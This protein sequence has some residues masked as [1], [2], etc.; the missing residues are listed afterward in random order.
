[1]AE[2]LIEE[3]IGEHRAALVDGGEIVAAQLRWPGALVAGQVEEAVLTSRNA[4]SARGIARFAGGAEVDVDRLPRDA[5]E[6]AALRLEVVRGATSERGRFKNAQARPTG[7]APRAA[8]RLVETLGGRVVR[9][10]EGWEELW[11]EAL[12]GEVEFPGGRLTI[13]LTAG[14]TVIDIDGSGP[15]PALAREAVPAVAGAIRRLDLSGSI[16][17]DFPTLAAKPDRQAIDAAL[18]QAL[19]GWPHERT[20][21]NGFGLIQIVARRDRPSLLELLARR[22]DAAARML[23]RRAERVREPGTLEL[24]ANPRVRA[25]VRDGWEAELARRTGRAIRWRE[26]PA[27]ALS[28]GFAQAVPA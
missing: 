2:W 15:P 20:A 11:S 10:I 13:E 22:P 16:A 19:A 27:L 21:M 5:R 17:I 6:G 23:M 12:T 4:G 9:D 26:D 7:I 1:M 14:L 8:P 3:G 28:A 18:A 25:A 24:A